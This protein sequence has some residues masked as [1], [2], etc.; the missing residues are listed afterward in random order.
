MFYENYVCGAE[1]NYTGYCN[2]E[3]DRLVDQQ[4]IGAGHG[5]AP[6]TRLADRAN[7]GRGT[8]ASGHLLHARGNLLAAAGQ[9]LDDHGQQPVQRL[10]LRRHLA[11]QLAL[12]TLPWNGKLI[13][14]EPRL[15]AKHAWSICT[16]LQ[17]AERTGG[18]AI[19]DLAIN[20]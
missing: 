7:A 18:L 10:A 6:R 11:R 3:F 15:Q 1:R 13:G 12:T 16:M 19:F 17:I 4:S 14:A 2:P 20:S 9:R 5:T 8:G